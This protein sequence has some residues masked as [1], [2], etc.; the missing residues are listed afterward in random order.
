M[1][2]PLFSN[3]T[4]PNGATQPSNPLNESHKRYKKGYNRF[5]Y[6]RPFNTTERFA[7]INLVEV[8][9][10]V[11]G[12]KLTFGNKHD[13]RTHTLSAPIDFDIFK[14]KAYFLVDNK[15]I[16]P[17][18]WEKVYKQP[19]KGDDVAENVN[20][21]SRSF[22]FIL[23]SAHGS[24]SNGT[25]P[26]FN[27][28]NNNTFTNLWRYLLLLESIFSNGSI[29]ANM[30]C[31][32]S[33]WWRVKNPNGGYTQQTFDEWLEQTFMLYMD[34]HPFYVR[35]PDLT[36]DKFFTIKE[37]D[38]ESMVDRI[39]RS[40]R[41]ILDMMRSY[42]HWEVQYNSDLPA[43]SAASQFLYERLS[44]LV[45]FG[46]SAA[47]AKPFNFA[48]L[49]AYQL[50]CNQ[51]YTN[52]SVDNV[53]N[54]ELWFQNM[55]AIV[56]KFYEYDGE[57]YPYF[58]YN[59]IKTDYDVTSG[60]VFDEV[61][62]SFFNGSSFDLSLNSWYYLHSIFFFRK[63]LRYGDYFVGAKTL[64]YA[65]GDVTAD[66]VGNGVSALDTTRSILMQRFLNAV[67]RANN[68]WKDYLKDVT[69]G[70]V[71]PNPLEPRFL[72][73]STSSVRCFEVEN[74]S[75]NQGN[76]VTILKTGNSDYVYEVEVGSP[77][78]IIGVSTYEVPAV[79]SQ[80]V[81]R[82]FYHADRFDMFNK[83]MQ[84]IGDQEISASERSA[85]LDASTAFGY[86]PRHM[87]YKQRY[88]IAAGA[89]VDFLPAYSFIKDNRDSGQQ[90]ID[91]APSAQKI[92]SAYLRNRNSEFDRFSSNLPGLSLAAYYHF[93]LRYFNICNAVRPM[94][95]SPS[96]L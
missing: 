44:M 19:N 5:N 26:L 62:S 52:D 65:P 92:N 3:A 64:P 83:F 27:S 15:A 43:Y 18:N 89:F 50:V 59:G 60:K 47:I 81:D 78:I 57:P 22:F 93:Q 79:Y 34:F 23:R 38:T 9:E 7:D 14:K 29:L 55:K 73:S 21:V 49:I 39:V 88:P 61:C 96:I 1:P 66:V 6:S 48:R 63:S 94:E 90:D 84:N 53:Y 37:S 11:E 10:G 51:F 13:I 12:D 28:T 95:Y 74:T 76:I 36:H 67:E 8:V 70:V 24:I 75:E 45:F 35:F 82:F 91:F 17:I 68:T 56:E 4:S 32:L 33:S 87:E 40:P 16:L 72:A 80:T 25:H 77:C 71:A 2:N 41:E 20:S 54:A 31:H 58:T 46:N 42:P 30:N 85:S 69:G 86:T